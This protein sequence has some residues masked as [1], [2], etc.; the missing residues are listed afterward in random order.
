[1]S[2]KPSLWVAGALALVAASLGVRASRADEFDDRL[3]EQHQK[4][5]ADEALEL[6]RAVAD[7]LAKVDA[8]H[9]ASP[10]T[11]KALRTSLARLR[12]DSQ[13]P[14]A[15]RATLIRQV[16]ERLRGLTAVAVQEDRHAAESPPPAA[17]STRQQAERDEAPPLVSRPVGQ[18]PSPRMAQP[19]GP[20]L[21]VGSPLQLTVTP[22][23]SADRR[24][25]R[26]NI[27]GTFNFFT[28]GPWRPIQVAVPTLLYGSRGPVATQP[29]KIVQIMLP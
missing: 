19:T 2:R 10:E 21:G 22:V 8:E 18:A 17:R 25:V 13:L 20:D 9:D 5:S 28:P 15:E 29:I 7:A 26:L 1:M 27:S 12:E 11:V 3:L 4:R 16:Q 24:F 14:R 6:K 23:V